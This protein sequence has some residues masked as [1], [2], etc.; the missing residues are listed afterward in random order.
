MAATHLIQKKGESTWYVRIIV[1]KDVRHAFGNRATL[2]KTTGTSNKAEAMDRRLPIL[3]EWKRMIRDARRKPKVQTHYDYIFHSN[4]LAPW[5]PPFSIG[6][7]PRWKQLGLRELENGVIGATIQSGIARAA[8]I[9]QQV[10]D[11]RSVKVKGLESL[12]Q[13][14]QEELSDAVDNL[15]SPFPGLVYQE[16]LA[17]PSK[18]TTR[19]PLTPSR[20]SAFRAY[21]EKAKVAEKTIDQQESKL[22]KLSSYLTNECLE[23]NFDTIAKWLDSLNLSSKTKTQYLLAGSVFWK[24]AIK[25]DQYWK[26]DFSN[27]PNPF[28]EHDLPRLR[29]KE[30]AQSSRKAFTIVEIETI[31]TKA[32]QDAPSLCPLIEIGSYTGLRIE[33]ICQLKTSSIIDMEGV[34]CFA[35]EDSKTAAGIRE[36]PIH[37]D[38]LPLVEHLAN[39]TLDGFLLPSSGGNQYGI[40]SDSYSKSFGR[41]KTGMGFGTRHVFH[42]V[43]MTV[44]TQLLRAGV[45][46]VVV[47]N[48]VG[49]ETG[50]VTYDV[51]DEGASSAQK[52]TAISN[53]HFNF[54]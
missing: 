24:W 8:D 3:A 29:G 19:S 38:L 43:R 37:P 50:L 2:T 5:S 21:R 22:E 30:K 41:L 7:A 18:F 23:L 17:K 12:I 25:N 42:S 34:Q 28:L 11:L 26:Q 4:A 49:H 53:L 32:L 40:R 13:Q 54:S 1:P 6:S 44:V 39:E 36:V 45:P 46:G 47:A 27:Q 9:A 33:E 48:I 14:R 20:L 35:I 31:Y 51:Y 15:G 52:L 16:L 10:K